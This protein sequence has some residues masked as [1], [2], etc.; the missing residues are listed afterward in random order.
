MSYAEPFSFHRPFP[1]AELPHL[2]D[3]RGEGVLIVVA[4]YNEIQNL[5]DLVADIEKVLPAADI[6]VIDDN[7]PDGTGHWCDEQSGRSSKLH[8]IHREGK[9]GLGTAIIAGLQFAAAGNY[10]FAVNMDADFSHHPGYLPHMV[11]AM[12]PPTAPPY[13]V[14]IGSR[15]IPE[16]GIIG[17]P[18]LRHLMSRGVNVYSRW[19][20]NLKPQ[21]CSGGFRC[22]RTSTLRKIEWEKI[23][24]TGY[25]FQEEFLW[26]LKSAGACIGEIPIVFIN[27]ARG[28]SKIDWR[29]SVNALFAIGRM[30]IKNW[31]GF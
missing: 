2:P 19:L 18:W 23:H 13:D 9:L 10:D 27:R 25:A 29:E 26:H 31:L 7:S 11:H 17:W 30:G 15:Y 24:S 28:Q 3:L 8:C 12:T 14:T 21:D 5:P 1:A 20:L 16:G 6:V 22:Y 4:T